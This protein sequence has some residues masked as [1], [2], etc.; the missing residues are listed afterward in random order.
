MPPLLQRL[1]V[2]RTLFFRYNFN[3]NKEMTQ[4]IIPILESGDVEFAGVFGSYA[5]GEE[6][7]DSDVDFLVRFKKPKSLFNIVGL[8]IELSEALNKKVDLVTE[9]GLCPH[10]KEAVAKDIQPIYGK[11]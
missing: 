11:R 1:K 10:I 6:M 7:S 3:M 8:E 9:S 4:K 5:R 2:A